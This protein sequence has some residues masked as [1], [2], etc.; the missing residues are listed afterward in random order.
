MLLKHTNCR[1]YMIAMYGKWWFGTCISSNIYQNL[2]KKK[3]FMRYD[4]M[5]GYASLKEVGVGK[6]LWQL[7]KRGKRYHFIHYLI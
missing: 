1:D 6:C 7:K 2:M 5:L 4:Y 3:S